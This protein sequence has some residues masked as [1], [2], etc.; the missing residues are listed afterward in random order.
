MELPQLIRVRELMEA[1]R[2][3]RLEEIATLF[4]YYGTVYRAQAEAAR[5]HPSLRD[6]LLQ[7]AEQWDKDAAAVD[8]ELAYDP[9]AT[10]QS[11]E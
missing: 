2:K 5:H 8:G 3:R 1:D 9:E 7:R 10:P 6:H 11:Q 4:R